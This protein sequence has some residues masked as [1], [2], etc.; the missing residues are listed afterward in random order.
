MQNDYNIRYSR[1]LRLEDFGPAAQE[2]LS[3]SHILIVGCGALGSTAAMYLAGSGAGHL[4]LVDFDTIDLSN[5]Q[6]QVFFTEAAAGSLKVE[7]LAAAVR[8]LNSGCEVTAHAELFSPRNLER[9]CAGADLIIDAADNPETTYL[10][11]RA[12]DARGIPYVTAGVS[13]WTAQ[14]LSHCP[15]D[16]HFSDLFPGMSSACG[17]LPCAVA[18]V[19][20]PLTGL[21][22]CLEATEAIKLLTSTGTP[23]RNR[24]LTL[25]LLN[26]SFI[27]FEI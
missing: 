14:V 4:T 22:A 24:L 27:N 3:R 7:A 26:N 20:G 2:R 19:F 17:A 12:A 15:G 8:A 11:E 9:V 18:G 5:L 16:L 13:G 1:N 6:R 23:L 25:N 10:I 21:V